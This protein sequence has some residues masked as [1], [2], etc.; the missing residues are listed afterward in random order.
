MPRDWNKVWINVEDRLP[1]E[2]VEVLFYNIFIYPYSDDTIHKV[3]Q[4]GHFSNNKWVNSCYDYDDYTEVFGEVTHWMP[5]P[6]KPE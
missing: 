3:I 4:K 2:N 6:K 1:R 5:L